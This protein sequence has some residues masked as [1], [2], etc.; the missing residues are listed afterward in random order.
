MFGLASERRLKIKAETNK[1]RA[2]WEDETTGMQTWK[3]YY[4]VINWYDIPGMLKS[5]L[6]LF[7]PQSFFV[8]F[9]VY[10]LSF[11]EFF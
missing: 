3:Y 2:S 5:L 11:V 4:A 8:L 10:L 1:T 9:F 6:V 7:G